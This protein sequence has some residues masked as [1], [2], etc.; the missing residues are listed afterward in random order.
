MEMALSPEVELDEEL[1]TEGEDEEISPTKTFKINYETMQITK[2]EIDGIEAI[3]QFIHMALRTQRYEH[4]IYT[5][6]YGSEVDELLSDSEVT[7][8]FKEMELPRLITEALVYDDRIDDVT[9][10]E[11]VREFNAFRV[12]FTVHSV[13]GLIMM[14][15]VLGQND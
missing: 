13:D 11:I 12:S 10:F 7:E 15:E 5:D 1:D 9:D 8:E 6:D 4:F 14:E 2:E 3:E